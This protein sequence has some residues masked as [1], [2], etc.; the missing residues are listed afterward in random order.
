MRRVSVK[1]TEKIFLEKTINIFEKLHY[2]QNRKVSAYY[3]HLPLYQ[4]DIKM[5]VEAVSSWRQEIWNN[6]RNLA[7][8]IQNSDLGLKKK[9]TQT[10]ALC[11]AN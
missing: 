7:I 4:N 2:I 9:K 5:S 6:G 1:A 10:V 3:I 11:T 8:L